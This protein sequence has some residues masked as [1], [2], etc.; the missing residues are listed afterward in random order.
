MA[1]TTKLHNLLFFLCSV[2]LVDTISAELS[3]ESLQPEGFIFVQ[4]ATHSAK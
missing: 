1:L 3:Q 2:P 4:G